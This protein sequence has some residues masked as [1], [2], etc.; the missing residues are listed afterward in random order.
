MNVFI[1]SMQNSKSGVDGMIVP[2]P[3]MRDIIDMTAEFISKSGKAMEKRILSEDSAS[4]KFAFI[5]P[6]N[7]F[8][9]Y[10]E[11]ALK[12]FKEG[13]SRWMDCFP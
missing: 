6:D 12:S 2:P 5:Y 9:P 11:M 7:P 10:Y 13:K 8:H 3:A 1:H 4:I